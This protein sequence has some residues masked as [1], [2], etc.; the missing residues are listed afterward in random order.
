MMTNEIPEDVKRWTAKP[1]Q[2]L[3]L[4]IVRG[5]ATAVE[6]G[7]RQGSITAS[8]HLAIPLFLNPIW[9]VMAHCTCCAIPVTSRFD[10]I[11]T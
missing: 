1:R 10:T 6:A 9:R 3:V 2:A 5:G 7:R 4:Q 8:P 11:V